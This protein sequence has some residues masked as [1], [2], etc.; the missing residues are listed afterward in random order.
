MRKVA[1]IV[2]LILFIIIDVYTLLLMSSDFLFPTRSIYVTNQDDYIVESIKAYFHIEY[3]ISKIVY[4]QGFPDGY[5]LDIYDGTGEKHEE[6]DDTFNVAE[7]DKIQQYF[8]G[9]KTDK[10]KYWWLFEAELIMEFFVI[11]VIIIASVRKNR[12]KYLEN[13]L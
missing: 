11:V 3:D 9:L 7:S 12:R 10:P 13:C 8:W 4:Q 1:F 2:M 6:F 5:Y